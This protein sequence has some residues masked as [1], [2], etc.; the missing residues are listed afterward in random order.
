MRSVENGNVLWHDVRMQTS[1]PELMDAS[2]R[3]CRGLLRRHIHGGS[4]ITENMGEKKRNISAKKT[5]MAVLF[6]Q[7]CSL[8]AKYFMHDYA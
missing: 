7:K 8:E 3:H 5:V 6:L 1:T 2:Q 4:L